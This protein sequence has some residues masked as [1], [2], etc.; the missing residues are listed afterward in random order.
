[1]L[2]TSHVKLRTKKCS[3]AIKPCFKRRCDEWLYEVKGRLSYLNG[4][5][6]SAD[7]VDHL[8]TSLN[9]CI[10]RNITHENYPRQQI[11]NNRILC[12]LSYLRI[13]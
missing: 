1:M 8:T 12:I 2:I 10:G 4:D 7:C 3:E 9:F 5:A 13:L 11:V 6:I